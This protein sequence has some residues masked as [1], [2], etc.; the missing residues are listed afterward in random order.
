AAGGGRRGDPAVTGRSTAAELPG[1]V[2]V[3]TGGKLWIEA[4]GNGHP[5]LL[6]HSGL[7]D[8]RMWDPQ[9]D[10]LEAA[11]HRPIRFDLRGFGR[12]DQPEAPYSHVADAVAVLDAL[13]VDRAV[14]VGCSLGGALDLVL[15]LTH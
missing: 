9:M 14:V 5:V 13:E 8:S 11:G 6:L 15:T 2:D 1:L 3:G 4:R 10:S 7:V 12:S